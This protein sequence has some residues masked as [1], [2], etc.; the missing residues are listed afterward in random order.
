MNY[1]PKQKQNHPQKG[2]SVKVEPIRS[3]RAIDR[4]KKILNPR[5]R[6]LFILRINR[7]YRANELLS[8]TWY[9]V[10]NAVAGDIL[11]L[12]QS[13]NEKHRRVILNNAAIEAIQYYLRNDERF[14]YRRPDKEDCYLFYTRQSDVLKVPVLINMVKDWCR[15]VGLQGNYG[16]HTLRKTW[17]YWQYK[18]GTPLPVLIQA[19]GHSSQQQTL[20]YMCIESKEVEA[21]YAMEL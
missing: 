21:V 3:K 14:K 10:R 18:N 6:C 15:S 13:K 11:E 12:K 4:I 8:I 5:D 7:G 9:Q 16:S 19:Y 20:A 1:N 17:G 2:S